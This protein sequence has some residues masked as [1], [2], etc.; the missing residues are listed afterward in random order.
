M[1][2]RSGSGSPPRS[3]SATP[4]TPGVSRATGSSPALRRLPSLR[5]Q[6]GEPAFPE[7]VAGDG[8]TH[9]VG[10]PSRSRS[11]AMAALHRSTLVAKGSKVIFVSVGGPGLV[12]VPQGQRLAPGRGRNQIGPAILVEIRHQQPRDGLRDRKVLEHDVVE[13]AETV[14]EDGHGGEPSAV[15]TRSRSRSLSTSRTAMPVWGPLPPGAARRR[16]RGPGQ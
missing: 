5:A 3:A 6:A 15:S 10:K 7:G 16:S 12:V 13:I 1:R 9:Q 4:R 2:S 14:V 11:A 8:Q